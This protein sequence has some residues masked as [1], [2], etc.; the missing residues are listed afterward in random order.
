MT[1]H[2]DIFSRYRLPIRRDQ[3][4]QA[5]AFAAPALRYVPKNPMFLVGA[6][7]I[8][9]GSFLAWRNRE[10][11]GAAAGPLIEEA[12]V[13][14]RQLMDEA[15]AKSHALMDDAAAK[16]QDLLDSARS[17]GEAVVEKAAAVRRGAAARIAA[18][19]VH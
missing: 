6:A 18:T 14:G 15:A 10:K 12:R 8:G 19:D 2:S 4:K 16:G 5:R 7:L 3:L 13:R 11:I 1:D 9:V 17:T